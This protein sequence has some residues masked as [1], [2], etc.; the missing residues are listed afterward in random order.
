[1]AENRGYISHKHQSVAICREIMQRPF[2]NWHHFYEFWNPIY[3][4]WTNTFLEK[5]TYYLCRERSL[6]KATPKGHLLTS[7]FLKQWDMSELHTLLSINTA[8][9]CQFPQLCF[10]EK[11]SE[12]PWDSLIGEE[13]QGLILDASKNF[14]LVSSLLP[15][16][17]EEDRVE[18]FSFPARCLHPLD[19]VE[20]LDGISATLYF[21][22]N[23]WHIS[24]VS[25]PDGS[26][27]L[28][29]F[30]DDNDPEPNTKSSSLKQVFWELFTQ[31]SYDMPKEH[32]YC[33]CF[34]IIGPKFRNVVYYPQNRLIYQ[35]RRGVDLPYSYFFSFKFFSFFVLSTVGSPVLKNRYEIA[36]QV[37]SNWVML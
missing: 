24:G 5:T 4:K 8:R 34:T 19:F 26:E 3:Q 9:H 17:I 14:S 30:D 33:Y 35:G 16:P 36:P 12:T 32:Q 11:T 13:C 28:R 1:M 10:F 15:K 37:F 23:L 20:S 31:F 22:S 21:Y 25:S 6:K 27:I 7:E 29:R 2:S 18:H